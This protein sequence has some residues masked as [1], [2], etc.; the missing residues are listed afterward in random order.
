MHR[1]QKNRVREVSLVSEPRDEGGGGQP[2]SWKAAGRASR[3]HKFRACGS[4][5]FSRTCGS[6]T[7][8]RCG[9]A[10]RAACK[11]EART[12]LVNR[13]RE[14]RHPVTGTSHK[15]EGCAAQ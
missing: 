7:S 1:E 3:T 2:K 11:G 8:G 5:V 13:L 9:P 6:Y 10:L 12:T 15:V 4:L 14:G